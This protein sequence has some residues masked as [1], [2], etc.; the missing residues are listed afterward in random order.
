M[1]SISV[2][3][4]VVVFKRQLKKSVA[5]AQLS[6]LDLLQLRKGHHLAK[7]IV[8]QKGEVKRGFYR[9]LGPGLHDFKAGLKRQEMLGLGSL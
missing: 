1:S 2:V 8:S 7:N 3:I 4:L 9:A 6:L 5:Q